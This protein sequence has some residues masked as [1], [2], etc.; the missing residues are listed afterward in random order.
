M[1]IHQAYGVRLAEC[2]QPHSTTAPQTAADPNSGQGRTGTLHPDPSR[3]A[4]AEEHQNENAM[5]TRWRTEL[6]A[7]KTVV[8]G[9]VGADC[10]EANLTLCGPS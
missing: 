4:P 1:P 2:L 9:A 8:A 6:R 10:R 3:G 7:M 5:N